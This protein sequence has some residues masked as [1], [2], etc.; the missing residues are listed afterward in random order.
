ML[1]CLSALLR[2][3]ASVNRVI[4]LLKDIIAGFDFGQEIVVYLAGVEH[5]GEH[6]KALDVRL[7]TAGGVFD[8][9]ALIDLESPVGG[10][11]E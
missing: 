2:E 1:Q 11:G 10:F 9:C 6:V 7:E 4:D 3:L 5:G 8:R